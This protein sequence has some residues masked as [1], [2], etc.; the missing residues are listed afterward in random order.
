LDL[1]FHFFPVQKQ[2]FYKKAATN[3]ITGSLDSGYQHL[4][5]MPQQFCL[6]DVLSSSLLF[7]SIKI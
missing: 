2:L 5:S 4:P 7:Q 6:Q 3:S 1:S